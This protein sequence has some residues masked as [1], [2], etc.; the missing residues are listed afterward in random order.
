[1]TMQLAKISK[2]RLH[3]QIF[4]QSNESARGVGN[5]CGELVL[6]QTNIDRLTVFQQIANSVCGQLALMFRLN[7]R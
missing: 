3:F 6:G 7:L 5:W 4:R 1:M 2:Q